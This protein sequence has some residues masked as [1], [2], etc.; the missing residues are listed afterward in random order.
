MKGSERMNIQ[1]ILFA[2]DFSRC[3]EVALQ[4]AVFVA[5]RYRAKLLMVHVISESVY[6][7]VPPEILDEAKIRIRA[8]AQ[9]KLEWSRQLARDLAVDVLLEEGPVADTLL[10]IS[11]S[12]AID[13]VVAG[14]R[15]HR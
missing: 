15:G 6:A 7:D 11:E 1:N 14:T 12:R 9:A 3:S 5:E 13:L 10:A 2:T 8:D 4:F